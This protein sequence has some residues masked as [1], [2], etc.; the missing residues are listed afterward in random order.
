MRAKVIPKSAEELDERGGGSLSNDETG[1][2]RKQA[3]EGYWQRDKFDGGCRDI[4]FSMSDYRRN[5][6]NRTER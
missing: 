2:L 1:M 6:A 5:F 3:G 4:A